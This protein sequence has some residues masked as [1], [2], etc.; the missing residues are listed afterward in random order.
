MAAVAGVA[1]EAGK[2]RLAGRVPN[3]QRFAANPLL[4][5]TVPSASAVIDGRNFDAVAPLREQPKLGNFWI[6]RAGLFAIGRSSFDVFDPNIHSTATSR[7]ESR[8]VR[9]EAE[10]CCPTEC[11]ATDSS[12]HFANEPVSRGAGIPVADPASTA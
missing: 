6:P 1:L 8:H 9:S 4:T 12:T 7:T 5:W 10:N 3:G 2:L 11:A